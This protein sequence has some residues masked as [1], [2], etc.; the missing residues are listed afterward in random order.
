MTDE[1]RIHFMQTRIAELEAQIEALATYDS[2][3]LTDR[4][5]L[6]EIIETR[7]LGVSPDDQDVVLEDDDWRLILSALDGGGCRIFAAADDMLNEQEPKP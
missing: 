2:N 6:R 4:D 3:A 1:T 7:L 5:Q